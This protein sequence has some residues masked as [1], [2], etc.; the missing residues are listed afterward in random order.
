MNGKEEMEGGEGSI[1]TG[2]E[3][4]MKVRYEERSV[5]RTVSYRISVSYYA[6]ATLITSLPASAML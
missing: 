6:L 5:F 4:K 2:G 1:G 3:G